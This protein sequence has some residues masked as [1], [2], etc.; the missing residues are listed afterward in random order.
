MFACARYAEGRA[1][2]RRRGENVSRGFLPEIQ[3]P[4]GVA[5]AAAF[6]SSMMGSIFE[7]P[8]EM[9]KHRTQVSQQCLGPSSSMGSTS[10]THSRHATHA[11]VFTK[12]S[13]LSFAAWQAGLIQGRMLNNMSAAL[14]MNGVGALYSGYLAFILKSLPYDVAELVTYSELSRVQGPLKNIP[15]GCRDILTG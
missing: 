7:A 4:T 14:R 8:M 1:E 9:F 2:R 11:K 13:G 6:V 10:C 12:D 15:V 3:S 5:L